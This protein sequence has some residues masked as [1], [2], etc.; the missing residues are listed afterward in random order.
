MKEEGGT[1]IRRPGRYSILPFK[2]PLKFTCRIVAPHPTSGLSEKNI[3]VHPWELVEDILGKICD[4]F[5][6]I[7]RDEVVAETQTCNVRRLAGAM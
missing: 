4:A 1:G 5:K 6:H 2:F 3:E 7:A